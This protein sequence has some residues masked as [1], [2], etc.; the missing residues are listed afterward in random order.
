MRV[1]VAG[2][3]GAIGQPLIAELI[4]KGHAVTAMTHSDAGAKRL[5]ALGVEIAIADALDNGAVE[6]ALRGSKAE[7][8][9][10]E[11]TSIPKTPSELPAY[12]AGDQK[13]RIE[14]G[15]NLHHAAVASGVRRYVQQSS[16]FSCGEWW[17]RG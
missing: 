8:V 12:A 15:G 6:A 3:S 17:P 2:A 4:R 16:G 1:F 14:G 5:R 11:L 13:L 9:I 7:A 10:D